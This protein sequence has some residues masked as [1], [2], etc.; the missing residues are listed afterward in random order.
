MGRITP[1]VKNLLI[2]NVIIFFGFRDGLQAFN[3]EP[4]MYLFPLG[5]GGFNPYQLFTHMF[6]HADERHLFFNMLTLF[7]LGPMTEQTLGQK[8]F[9]LMF[10]TA[11]LIG[12]I[13]HLLSSNAPAVGAS[14]AINGVVVA[15]ATMYPN[16]KLMVFPLPFEVKAKYLV[17]AFVLIDFFFGVTNYQS[18]IAHFAHL[19]G[20]LTGFVMVHIWKMANLR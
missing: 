13:A 2:I 1:V 10:I 16:L 19:G 9:L 4:R 8:K 12:G 17:G 14:G 20:A 11:G 7:F 15:F 18:G 6:M 5:S 3:V